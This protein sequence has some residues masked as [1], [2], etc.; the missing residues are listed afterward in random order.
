MYSVGYK[1]LQVMMKD[2]LC[3]DKYCFCYNVPADENSF[4]FFNDLW[5]K[6]KDLKC[7]IF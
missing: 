7:C 6:Y 5:L 1:C 4:F 3:S 2:V